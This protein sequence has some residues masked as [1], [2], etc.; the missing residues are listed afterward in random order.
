MARCDEGYLC[1]VCGQEVQ[2]LVD[3]SLYLQYVIGWVSTDQL[4]TTPDVHL[5]C[6]PGLAQFIVAE[7]FDP[8]VMGAGEFDRR[9]LDPNFVAQRTELITR[10]YLRL[11]Q[12]QR[13]RELPI[14]Q[15]PLKTQS[16]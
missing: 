4:Q 13:H 3:S 10:G 6:N 12:L 14:D 15:Y 16:S 1:A 7:E 2:R 8:P 9:V 5:R 11:R